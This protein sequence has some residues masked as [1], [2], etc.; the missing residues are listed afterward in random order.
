MCFV[1]STPY[2]ARIAGGAER[3]VGEAARALAKRVNVDL[4]YLGPDSWTEIGSLGR[5]FRSLAPPLPERDRLALAPRLAASAAR[6]D[7]V[8]IHQ[9]GTAT[10]QLTALA[11]RLRGRSVFV[12]D[13]GASGLEL[14]R[15]MQLDHL[16]HGFLEVSAFAARFTPPQRT[17]IVYGGVDTERF[18]PRPGRREPFAAYVGRI[19]PHKGLDWLLRSL[20]PGLPLV[21]AGRPDHE[22]FPDYLPLLRRMASGRPVRFELDTDDE[23]VARLL[24]EATV[25]VLP[26]VSTDV[27]GNTRR[28]P[29]L[30]GLAAV[31]AMACGTPVVCSRAGA[32]PEL[33]SDGRTGFVVGERDERGL[34][35]ALE[36]LTADPVVA[37]TM[38]REARQEVVRRFTWDRVADR[39]LDAYD[40]LAPAR[41]QRLSRR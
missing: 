21:I 40:D 32:L 22:S 28:V 11:A 8:H 6:A 38:G 33:V 35:A 26:S 2:R 23:A 20:P 25:A 13:H 1:L 19:L 36:R 4:A 15:R 12:T 14:G 18:R 37:A 9:F 3:W 7:V 27:Y 31:E 10:A 16:F 29:E 17:R 41:R 24:A 5:H 30:F 39:C 34:R